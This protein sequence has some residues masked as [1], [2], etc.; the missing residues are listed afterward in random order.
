MVGLYL[1]NLN[2]PVKD[3]MEEEKSKNTISM[4]TLIQSWNIY[5][6]YM[7]I[8]GK[9]GTVLSRG[10]DNESIITSVSVPRDSN[11]SYFPDAD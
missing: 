9:Y 4:Q 3:Y 1:F 7:I 11:V 5:K 6:Y 8:E 10:T 2:W